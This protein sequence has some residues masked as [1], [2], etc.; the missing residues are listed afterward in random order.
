MG[1]GGDP[2]PGPASSHVMG[3]ISPAL[4][5]SCQG[6]QRRQPRRTRCSAC[7]VLVW[8]LWERVVAWRV[9]TRAYLLSGAAGDTVRWYRLET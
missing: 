6:A 8:V 4:E 2:P 9:P 7:P 3:H 1:G 5:T